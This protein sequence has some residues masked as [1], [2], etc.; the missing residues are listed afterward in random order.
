[1]GK[2]R[3]T[4]GF[5]P[6]VGTGCQHSNNLVVIFVP[7]FFSNSA[8][9]KK[10]IYEQGN[11]WKGHTQSIKGRFNWKGFLSRSDLNVHL[12][13]QSVWPYLTWFHSDVYTLPL[14][15]PVL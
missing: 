8:L 3:K 12:A 2:I 14:S 15:W 4:F 10:Y 11:N 1:M 7:Q 9:N 5:C 13:G 6:S